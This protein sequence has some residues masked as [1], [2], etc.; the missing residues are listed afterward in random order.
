M[1]VC[2]QWIYIDPR[3]HDLSTNYY[4]CYYYYYYYYLL[5]LGLC[6]VAVLQKKMDVRTKTGHT[7]QGNKTYISRKSNTYISREMEVSGQLH[8]RRLK[9]KCFPHVPY[10]F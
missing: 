2:G 9:S 6:P 5:Q 3:F 4:Y 7:W 1:R 10:M 8:M